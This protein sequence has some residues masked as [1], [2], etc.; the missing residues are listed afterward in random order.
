MAKQQETT[1]IFLA[2]FSN[3]DVDAKIYRKPV[4]ENLWLAFL[5]LCLLHGHVSA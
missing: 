5:L 4:E 2:S 1:L 3:I